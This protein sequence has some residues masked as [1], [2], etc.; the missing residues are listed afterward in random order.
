MDFAL[1]EEQELLRKTGH[2]F[3]ENE[4]PKSLVR[5]SEDARTV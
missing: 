3:L 5:E 1:S 4:W 2:D